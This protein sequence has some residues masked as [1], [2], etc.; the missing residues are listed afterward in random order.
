MLNINVFKDYL[1]NFSL[2]VKGIL[3]WLEWGTAVAKML[4]TFKLN[5]YNFK[6]Y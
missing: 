3:N 1:Q 6:A 5:T 4:I 2:E